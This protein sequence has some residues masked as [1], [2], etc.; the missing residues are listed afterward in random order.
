MSE[1]ESF[2]H[3]ILRTPSDI[4]VR[5]VYADWL[6]E[7]GVDPL[8]A[9]LI[10][11]QCRGENPARVRAILTSEAAK[12]L[13]RTPVGDAGWQN[14]RHGFVEIIR[15]QNWMYGVSRPHRWGNLFRAHPIVEVRSRDLWEFEAVAGGVSCQ[16]HLYGYPITR[17][18]LPTT[19]LAEIFGEQPDNS[20]R[21]F[22]DMNT[23]HT[24]LSQALVNYGRQLAGLPKLYEID[25]T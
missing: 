23:A 7:H 20:Y 11:L 10:R 2:L 4:T 25:F 5:L 15:I 21:V 1:R 8:H 18:V 12:P 16:R 17:G 22:P 13:K 24:I 14:F 3:D 6:D 9:E 19:D